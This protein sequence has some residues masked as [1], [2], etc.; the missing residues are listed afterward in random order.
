VSE[1]ISPAALSPREKQI[2]IRVQN[3]PHGGSVRCKEQDSRQDETVSANETRVLS[4]NELNVF[5]KK[6]QEYERRKQEKIKK[7]LQEKETRETQELA[8]TATF[9][10]MLLAKQIPINNKHQ[11]QNATSMCRSLK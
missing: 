5:I 7:A 4:Q 8:K 1:K 10:P 2:E 3:K 6:Q 11:G 9:R